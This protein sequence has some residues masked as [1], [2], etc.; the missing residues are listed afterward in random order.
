MVKNVIIQNFNGK[1]SDLLENVFMGVK[2]DK[3]WNEMLTINVCELAT[4]LRCFVQQHLGD[5]WQ[6]H[7]WAPVFCGC[8]GNK[9]GMAKSAI[10]FSI[11]LTAVQERSA[12]KDGE[13]IVEKYVVP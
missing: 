9:T 7:G 13:D 4:C 8:T 1:C 6:M 11:T 12:L 3:Q 5:L 10:H 2:L